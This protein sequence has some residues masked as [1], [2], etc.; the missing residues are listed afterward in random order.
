MF[1][2]V[3]S[4]PAWSDAL[5]HPDEIAAELAKSK[6]AP[7]DTVTLSLLDPEVL[8]A[9]GRVDLLGGS[10]GKRRGWPRRSSGY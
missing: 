4:V 9:A 3:A 8:S 6:P 7:Q 2:T 10:S 5:D 1:D